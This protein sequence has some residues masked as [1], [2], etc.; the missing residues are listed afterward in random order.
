VLVLDLRSWQTKNRPKVDHEHDWRGR[1]GGFPLLNSLI[2]LV[3]VLVLVLDLRSWQTKNG[4]KVERE[5]E[6]EYDWGGRRGG[7]LSSTL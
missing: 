4:P 1:R 2:V 7:S 6:H 3:I 5:H